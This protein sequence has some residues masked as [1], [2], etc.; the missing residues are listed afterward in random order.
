MAGYTCGSCSFS[1]TL[2]QVVEHNRNMHVS[3]KYQKT[4]CCL[5]SKRVQS[6]RLRFHIRRRHASHCT[7]HC[8]GCSE[9]FVANFDMNMHVRNGHCKLS[10]RRSGNEV[11]S[12]QHLFQ[13][14]ATYKA[15][16]ST[17]DTS[18]D[19]ES[20]DDTDSDSSSDIEDFLD[21]CKPADAYRYISDHLQPDESYRDECSSVVEHLANFF[22]RSSGFTVNKFIKGGSLGK[23]TAIK[24]KSDVDLVMF[25]SELPSIDSY[26]Y[27]RQ[28]RKQ[29]DELES[30]LQRSKWSIAYDLNV[31]GRT[32]HAV[33]LRVQTK[34]AHQEPH[35]VDLLLASDLLGPSPTSRKKAEVYDMMGSMDARAREYC[36][37]ALVELQRDFVRKQSAEVKAIIRLLKIWKALCVTET[38][39]TSY[40]L[41]LLCIHTWRSHMTVASA[42]EAVLRKLSDYSSINACWTENYSYSRVLQMASQRF[43]FMG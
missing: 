5:C 24:S 37:A 10:N 7:V 26:D 43:V 40:P 17:T 35:D 1:G 33:K 20:D 18:S 41:E 28:L 21:R 3:D 30:T 16:A 22:K 31:V 23:G 12:F 11:H 8:S 34:K 42:F 25:I 9:P 36:S 38:S 32:G 2:L 4:P 15:H 39:L 27:S 6:R 14:T 13:T 19:S 29:L